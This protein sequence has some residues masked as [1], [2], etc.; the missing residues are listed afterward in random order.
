MAN[1][2]INISRTIKGITTDF[3]PMQM[4]EVSYGHVLNGMVENFDG[5]GFPNIQNEPSNLLCTNFPVGYDVVGFVNVVEQGRVIWFLHNPL[6]N[7]S[8]IGESQNFENCRDNA[9]NGLIAGCDD[10][11]AVKLSESTPLENVTQNPCCVYRTIKNQTC[12]N[13]STLHPVDAVE[14]RIMPCSLQIFFTDDNN[15]R[16]WLEFEYTDDNVTKALVV[17]QDFLEITGFQVP[18]CEV[19]IYGTNIDC[20][21][22]NVQPN[23]STPCIDFIDLVPGGALKAGSYQFF[24][25]YA[26][27]NGEKLSSYVSSTNPIP[28]KTKEVSFETDY[29]TDRAIALEINNID[30]FGPYQYY[31]LAVAKTVNSFTSFNLVGTFPVT[32]TKYTY[33]GSDEA[34]IKLTEGDIFQRLP[35]YKTATDVT[36]SNNILFWAGLKEF[37]KPNLQRVANNIIL[38]WQT[39]AIPEAVYRNPRN[40]NKYRGYMRDE[41]YPFGIVFIY[42]NGEESP[43]YHIP[44]RAS[45]PTDLEI[46]AN[47]D[48]IQ[49]DNCTDQTRN[50]RWQVYNTA[51]LLGGNLDIYKECEENCYQYGEFAYWE[52]T[53]KYPNNLQIWGALCGQPIRHHK[54]PDSF[55]THIHNYEN[56]YVAY[57]ENNLVFP[58]GVKVDHASVRASIAT[59]VAGGIISAEEAAHIVS[60][61]IVRGNRFRNKSIQAKGLLFDVNQYQRVDGVTPIDQE[62]IYFANYPYNDLRANPFVTNQM[63]NYDNHNDPEG[64]DLPFTFS[65]RYTFH[66]PDTHFNEPTPGVELKL[67]TAEYG[68]AEGYYTKSKKQAKQRL[69]SDSSYA[70]A[71]SGGIVA[72]ML[73][74]EE[75]EC[76]EYIVRSDYITEQDES[77]WNSTASGNTPV[78]VVTGASPGATTTVITPSPFN[79]NGNGSTKHGIQKEHHNSKNFLGYDPIFGTNTDPINNVDSYVQKTCKG[80]RN[81]Y[82][83]NPALNGNPM[84]TVLGALGGIIGALNKTADFLRVV[85]DEMN[86]ILRLIESLTPYRDWTVQYHSVGK[87]NNYRTVANSGNKRRKIQ[88]WAYLKSENNSIN[89]EVDPITGQFNSIKF[90]NWHRES[91]LYLKYEG[92]TVPNAGVVSTVTDTSRVPLND[93]IFNCTLDKKGYSPISSY[94]AALKNF[95]PDQ[96]GTI[97]NIDYIP[98]DSCVFDINTSNDE[99][100]GVYGGDTFINR[101]GLK[102]KVPYFLATTFGLPSGTDFDFSEYPNLA[103][104]RH[105][106]NNTAT[107]G[108]EIDSILDIINPVNI[109][110]NLGRPKSIRDC[111]T[112][113]FFY[114]NGYIYLYHYGIPYFLVESDVNVDYRYAENNKEKSYYP[115]QGDLDF[116]LQEENVPISEDNYYLYNRDYSKQ[117]RETPITVDGPDFDPSRDCVVEHPNRIIYATDSNW[118]TYKA[119]DY[120][121]FPLSQGRITSIE[122]IENETVLVRTIN[123]ASVFK[124]FNLIPTDG[125]TIQVGSGGVFKNKPQQFAETTLGYVGSQHKAILHTEYGHVWVDAKRGQVFNM[126][127]GGNGID[128]I[129]KEGMK[130]WFKE[131]LPFRILR[132]FQNMPES[133]IDRNF[134]GLGIAMAFDKRYNRIVITKRDY[135]LKNKNVTYNSDTKQFFLGEVL[136]KLG[137]KRY[138]KDTSWTVSYNFFTKT[139]VS[140]HSYKPNYYIDF[141]E[142]FGSGV[143][144]GLWLHNLTNASYQVF[145]GKLHPFV[146]ESIVKFEGPIRVLNSVE[147]DTE[148][149]RYQNEYDYTI[150]KSLPG[151]NKTIVYNDVYNSG[152]LELVKVDKNNLTNI[153]KYPKRNWNSWE[154]EVSLAN[155][156][157]RFNQF[158]NLVK[159]G[160]E[161]PLWNYSGNNFEKELNPTA[162]NYGKKDFDL[163]RIRGQWFKL[164]MI[165]DKD[166]NNKIIS[167]FALSNQTVTFK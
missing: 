8:E 89:E 146:A 37:S 106:Y 135:K 15:S 70:L 116:W 134:A 130:N 126:S 5:N 18:P 102:V 153:G 45:R 16:R 24:I 145:Y 98:T 31:N 30:R 44:G 66:S 68:N 159:N 7:A 144:G 120:Y 38:F 2:K 1:N 111:S 112:N 97:F 56:G 95:V 104:P 125:D 139:W 91:S 161:I 28:I 80:T 92:P 36:S 50:K 14:Y 40:V 53:E 94:Y 42:S 10:C 59:A 47:N 63:D 152:L 165:N 136:V 79:A 147:F 67:E 103:F 132:D 54:F 115:L 93:G 118:L 166:S 124:S 61:R 158:Y 114:Q 62:P 87:Y 121:D 73:R 167:K 17:K 34:E 85:L 129:S 52:S 55:T 96:Y 65:K 49:E 11:Q 51:T 64:A 150:K 122:G 25:A 43:A 155:Y 109:I 151:F 140:F 101:F 72:A 4:D 156:K 58:I 148:V 41:V 46:I 99:C 23:L 105:Y 26:D 74:T 137:D 143:E 13:F 57:N 164:M 3:H 33:T 160:S 69:L 71:L 21:K 110:D 48:V 82:F 9:T 86:I 83:N 113:K 60:Y 32:Q 107:M 27:V 100:R 142:F 19:P 77:T 163:S 76:I 157:W 75:K 138:F 131:N 29:V 12:F 133:D 6:T 90:N 35:Y 154:I 123:S 88:S 81:Q 78:G 149:R 20:N 128:E 162:L 108:S 127:A 141:V 117:N 84:G 22:M 39:I 119:N